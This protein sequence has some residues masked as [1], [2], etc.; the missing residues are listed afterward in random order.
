M[1]ISPF[2]GYIVD[3]DKVIFDHR[4]YDEMREDFMSLYQKGVFHRISDAP[5]Y[6]ILE[7][8]K[9]NKYFT[10][11]I[12]LT[13]I[14]DYTKG[15]IK[16]HEQTI[17]KKQKIHK[18][19]LTSRKA[20]IK[21][22][23][24]LINRNQKLTDTLHK[25]KKNA[26]PVISVLFPDSSTRQRLWSV[27]DQ[28][29]I[30]QINIQFK[31]ENKAIIADGHHRFAAVAKVN[32]PRSTNQILTAYFT[33]DQMEVYSFYRILSPLKNQSSHSIL[34]AIQKKAISWIQVK[35]IPMEPGEAF[36]LIHQ[37]RIYAFKLK[38]NRNTLWPHLFGDQI[39]KGIF[40]IKNESISKRVFFEEVTISKKEYT[41]MV[42]Q[43]PDDFIFRLPALDTNEVLHTKTLLP[44]KSTLMMPRIINGLVVHMI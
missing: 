37:N 3:S 32:G 26:K 35:S 25:I 18:K 20:M 30:A 2:C 23:A 4:F 14:L 39:T 17:V 27:D 22:A 7:I 6:F 41:Q 5:A 10:G 40:K 9:A 21:P 29:T 19:L 34:Q 33:T 28:H 24:V 11:I 36:Y 43:Y 38:K 12:T 1:H 16:A 44:P 13:S 15:K 8:K 42:N 31:K